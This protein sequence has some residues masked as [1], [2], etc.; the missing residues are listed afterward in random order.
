MCYNPITIINPSKYVSLRYRERYLLQVPCGHCAQC[1][2]NKSNEWY[3][4][5]YHQI[6]DCL[7]QTNGTAGSPFVLFD[8][9]TYRNED[10]PHISDFVSVPDGC[11]YP[12]FNSRH[13]QLFNKKLRK[14]CSRY[15]SQY[16]FFLTS[17][18]GTSEHHTHRPHYHI[19]FYSDGNIDPFQLSALIAKC[20]Q[21]GRTDGLPY[22]SVYYVRNNVFTSDKFAQSLRTCRYVSKYIQKSCKFEKEI[23]HRLDKIMMNIADRM[24]DGWID[25]PHAKRVRQK[26]S[27]LVCQFH[28]QS[29]E[30]GASYMRDVDITDFSSINE[31]SMPDS[32]KVHLKIPLP[33]YYKRK[34]YYKVENIDGNDVWMP[35]DLGMLYLQSRNKLLLSDL[36][37][38]FRAANV[39]AGT[40]FDYKKLAEYVMLFRGRIRA[41]ELPKSPLDKYETVSLFN[42]STFS[43]REHLDNL[44]LTS[45]YAGN[46]TIGYR[47]CK[48]WNRIKFKDFISKYV[49]LDPKNVAILNVYDQQ[50]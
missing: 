33:Q 39:Q 30:Y 20:W 8:T 25:S 38:R 42:Y 18:Y 31:L 37:N 23:K 45:R 11:D 35:T 48:L 34:F 41:V 43:D 36:E 10:L 26:Y 28:R 17:E 47:T 21:Y 13:V 50:Q 49:I 29:K 24:I 46:N 16:K 6:L 15:N 7:S 40:N 1:V 14:A 22:K 32:N 27:R 44:G 5:S 4:R 19:L 12:C 3:F 9:L 2:T